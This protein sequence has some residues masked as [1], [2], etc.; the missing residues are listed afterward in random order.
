MIQIR[1]NYRKNGLDP[2]ICTYVMMKH[3]EVLVSEPLLDVS[4]PSSE[5]V[6]NYKHLK[7]QTSKKNAQFCIE[8]IR[9]EKTVCKNQDCAII[10]P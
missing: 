9:Q 7:H 2:L 6:V 3:L 4:F 8:K 5:I 1:K 10:Q